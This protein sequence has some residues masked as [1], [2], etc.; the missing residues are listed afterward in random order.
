VA[1]LLRKTL[2][3]DMDSGDSAPLVLSHCADHVQ[4]VP[5]SGVGIG[6]DR[7]TYRRGDASGIV[8]HLRHRDQTVIGI[9]QCCRGSG[10]GH[11]H[12]LEARLLDQ[13]RG[14]AVIGSRRND[15]PVLAQEV[16]ELFCCV[17][18]FLDTKIVAK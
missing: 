17:H 16:A 12:G 9:A 6:D 3:F 5:V 13:P 8:C 10:A 4:L 7:Y 2:V 11:V 14:D 1:A 15:H 18:S